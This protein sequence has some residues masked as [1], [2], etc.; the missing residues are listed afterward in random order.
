MT[1]FLDRMLDAYPG[2]DCRIEGLDASGTIIFVL[3]M[4]AVVVILDKVKP[5][6]KR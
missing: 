1:D 3:L 4:M 6:E 2:L 5:G